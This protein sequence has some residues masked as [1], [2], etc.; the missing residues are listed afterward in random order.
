MPSPR[1][2]WQELLL[3]HFFLVMEAAAGIAVRL[4]F[5]LSFC[6]KEIRNVAG[7]LRREK[8]AENRAV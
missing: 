7:Q 1:I 6:L 5:D 8:V 3:Y 4:A 2:K